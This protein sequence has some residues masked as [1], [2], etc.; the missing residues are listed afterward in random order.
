VGLP[1]RGLALPAPRKGWVEGLG[2]AARRVEMGQRICLPIFLYF[3]FRLCEKPGA[4]LH[5]P[6]KL[7]D[8][9]FKALGEDFQRS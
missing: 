2:A 5:S 1:H 8:G 7:R 9:H 4:A 6:Q 3:Y